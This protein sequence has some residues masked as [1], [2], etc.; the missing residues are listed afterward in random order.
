[1]LSNTLF[2]NW[3]LISVYVFFI[4]VTVPPAEGGRKHRMLNLEGTQKGSN[5]HPSWE[6]RRRFWRTQLLSLALTRLY[7][8]TRI[9]I[10]TSK[11]DFAVYIALHYITL[12]SLEGKVCFNILLDSHTV[13]RMK[14]AQFSP[15]QLSHGEP[16][17]PHR[18]GHCMWS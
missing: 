15:F 17:I 3:D 1:M 11:E 5:S 9:I 18:N 12:H 7:P 6:R 4:G 14:E 13:L 16:Q 2:P 8:K 10:L